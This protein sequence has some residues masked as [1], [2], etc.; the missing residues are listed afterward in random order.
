MIRIFDGKLHIYILII[1]DPRDNTLAQKGAGRD[2]SPDKEP[3]LTSHTILTRTSNNT[4]SLEQAQ[5][6]NL[7]AVGLIY[8]MLKTSIELTAEQLQLGAPELQVLSDRKESLGLSEQGVL[9]LHIAEKRGKSWTNV[10]PPFPPIEPPSFGE[11]K[12]WP[13]LVAAECLAAYDCP[14]TG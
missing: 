12:V 14:G 4:I 2:T 5:A 3:P 8:K 11:H 6:D 9:Q 13:T 7:G 10:F 1:L